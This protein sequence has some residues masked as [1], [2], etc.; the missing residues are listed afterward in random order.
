M[1]SW[2]QWICAF[3]PNLTVINDVLPFF[4]VMVSLSNGAMRPYSML[5]VFWRYRMYYV[6][7]STWWI[8][9]VLAATLN[10]VPV[11]CSSAETASFDVPLGQTCGSYAGEFARTAGG[12]LVD[13]DATAACQY[14]AYSMGDQYLSSLNIA[15]GENRRNFGIFI[16]FVVSNWALVYFV[17]TVRVRGWSFG[18][19]WLFGNFGKGVDRVKGLFRSRRLNKDRTLFDLDV[20]RWVF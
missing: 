18:L 5:P 16:A 11:E 8:S 1:S 6:N 20:A 3:G 4:F 17:Y 9:G 2:G 12:Y 13:P 15:A 14:C 10:G 19:G 7:P